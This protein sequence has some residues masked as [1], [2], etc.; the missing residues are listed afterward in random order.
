MK[1]DVM[2]RLFGSALGFA[3]MLCPA[4]SGAAQTPQLRAGVSVQMPATVNAAAVPDAD[5]PDSLVVAVSRGGAAYLEITPVDAA[6]LEAKLTSALAGRAVKAVYVKGD[7]RT[8]SAQM[9][10]VLE[11]VAGAGASP[12][13]LLTDQREASDAGKV[14]IPPKGLEVQID[15]PISSGPRPVFIRIEAP[16]AG[17]GVF[18][19]SIDNNRTSLAALPAAIAERLPNPERATIAIEA[20]G[21]LPFGDLVRVIDACRPS[22]ATIG[23]GDLRR[24]ARR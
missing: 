5:A 16:N 4:P 6:A 22:G 14:P 21:S 12:V 8:L 15:G 11:A 3:L 17:Q 13:I 9:A 19:L 18:A 10:G 1:E 23:I 24:Q 20:N 7:A 2:K